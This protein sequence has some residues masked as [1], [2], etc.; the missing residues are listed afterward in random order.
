MNADKVINIFGLIVTGTIV[1]TIVAR[2]NSATIVTA[3][4]NG[5][6][7]SLSRMLGQGVSLG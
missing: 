3:W 6:N 2:K 5:F 4:W 7:D 1:T